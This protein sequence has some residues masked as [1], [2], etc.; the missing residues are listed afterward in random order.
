LLFKQIA[1][2]KIKAQARGVESLSDRELEVF[3]LIGKGHSAKASAHGLGISV[4]TIETH[5][6]RIKEKLGLR[7]GDALKRKASTWLVAGKIKMP[8][9]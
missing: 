5:R 2:G 6:Q 4:K 7:S 3:R 8:D 1:E 9:R